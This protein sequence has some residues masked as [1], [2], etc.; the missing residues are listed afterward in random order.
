MDWFQPRYKEDK[1]PI[2]LGE[3]AAVLLPFLPPITTAR[4]RS[5]GGMGLALSCQPGARR[6]ERC[7]ALA[8]ALWNSTVL[9]EAAAQVSDDLKER[10][11]GIPWQHR[12]SGALR[13]RRVRLGSTG[14]G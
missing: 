1:Q 6:P 2:E 4:A 11:A 10:F 9:A 14:R 5:W 13:L 12:R 8:P 3:L 7:G